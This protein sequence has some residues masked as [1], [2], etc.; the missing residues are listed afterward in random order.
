MRKLHGE[1]NY[2]CAVSSH[3]VIS[4]ITFEQVS[5]LSA[6]GGDQACM[7]APTRGCCGPKKSVLDSK[8]GSR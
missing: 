2:V 5:V 1:L 3:N 6:E 4:C 7:G 8:A